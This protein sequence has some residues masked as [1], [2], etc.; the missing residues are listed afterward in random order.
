MLLAYFPSCFITFSLFFILSSSFRSSL[1][2]TVPTPLPKKKKKKKKRGGFPYFL[3]LSVLDSLTTLFRALILLSTAQRVYNHCTNRHPGWFQLYAIVTAYKFHETQSDD[4][5]HSTT[6]HLHHTTTLH[7]TPLHSTTPH[8]TPLH[9]TPLHTTPH[10][11][12]SHHTTRHTT[13]HNTT[14]HYDVQYTT[15]RDYTS[16]HHTTLHCNPLHINL[17]QFLLPHDTS[18]CKP[19]QQKKTP[20]SCSWSRLEP[21]R[22]GHEPASKWRCERAKIGLGRFQAHSARVGVRCLSLSIYLY[23]PPSLPLSLSLSF[24][25]SL[26]MCVLCLL[27]LTYLLFDC[28]CAFAVACCS[29]S[30]HVTSDVM[31]NSCVRVCVC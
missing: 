5:L 12:T 29:F 31:Y 19:E 25:F 24:S 15:R 18:L 10:H 22:T 16:L 4:M 17:Q 3:L 21:S 30:L 2:L 27:F 28:F 13:P 14:L 26:C 1:A 6:T 7:Y 8:Y 9:S 20:K 11:T 23:L